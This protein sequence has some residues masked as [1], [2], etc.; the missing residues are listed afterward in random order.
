MTAPGPTQ[1]AAKRVRVAVRPD[2]VHDE[3][4]EFDHWVVWEA[5]PKKNGDGFDKVPYCARTGRKAS[6]RDSRTWSAFEEAVAAYVRDGWDGIGFVLS[7]GDPFVG[8]DLD[9]ARDPVSGELAEWAEKAIETFGGYAEA[10]P[11]GEGVHI[12]VKGD[13]PSK[14]SGSIEVYSMKRF[15]TVT[16]VRP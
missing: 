5:E 12:Y 6:T 16:G 14:K 4:K 2:G 9:G 11:S 13:V 10:S 1:A 8:I 7:S 15:F 3:L